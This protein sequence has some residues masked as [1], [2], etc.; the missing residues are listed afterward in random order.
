[1]GQFHGCSSLC[2]DGLSYVLE[3]WY[4]A[5][6]DSGLERKGWDFGGIELLVVIEEE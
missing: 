3:G 2:S 4:R 1:M 5:E 6:W